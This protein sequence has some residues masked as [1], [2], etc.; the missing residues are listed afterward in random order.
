MPNKLH[1]RH[2]RAGSSGATSSAP[3]ISGSTTS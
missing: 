3:T 1:V 2:N